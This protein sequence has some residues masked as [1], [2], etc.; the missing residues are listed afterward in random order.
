MQEEIWK[1]IKIHSGYEVS[2]LGRV[3]SLPRNVIRQGYKDYP[4]KGRIIKQSLNTSGYPSFTIQVDKRQKT[5][6]V[7]CLV[8]EA[9]LGERPE[10]MTVSHIDGNSQNNNI[11]NLCYESLKDNC[12]RGKRYNRLSE[13]T[14]RYIRQMCFFSDM[15]PKEISDKTGCSMRHIS[16]LR[17]R[18]VSL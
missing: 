12:G 1:P 7:H 11:D 17:N 16:K 10:G 18:K 14:K 8:A 4:I 2:S 5:M 9:F 13:D 3:R 6:R 15:S